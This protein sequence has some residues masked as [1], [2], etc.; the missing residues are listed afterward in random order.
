MAKMSC[1]LLLSN[2]WFIWN[3]LL[4]PFHRENLQTTETKLRGNIS[5][6][7]I[8]KE[9]DLFLL[10]FLSLLWAA[11][12][13]VNY[14]CHMLEIF[15]G[16]ELQ[17]SSIMLNKILL[18]SIVFVDLTPSTGKPHKQ[19]EVSEKL[20]T[21]Y[22]SIKLLWCRKVCQ[23]HKGLK[24]KIYITNLNI[25][26]KNVNLTL[27]FWGTGRSVNAEFWYWCVSTGIHVN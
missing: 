6:R 12:M 2:V 10:W 24:C 22:I 4:D 26:I 17:Y 27:L 20:Q 19:F 9:V 5:A 13:T 23:H 18:V 16:Q 7:E 21:I 8:C 14:V 15:F 11:K 3:F 1:N 25:D